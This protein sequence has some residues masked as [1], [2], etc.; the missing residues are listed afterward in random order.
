MRQFQCVLTTYDSE[1]RRK[2]ILKSITLIKY[3]AHYLCLFAKC[4][5]VDQCKIT[6]H[7]MANEVYLLYMTALSSNKHFAKLVVAKLYICNNVCFL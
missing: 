5:A 6:C 3:H 2:T 4:Q 1:K 7:Y